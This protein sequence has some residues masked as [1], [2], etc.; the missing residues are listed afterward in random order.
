MGIRSSTMITTVMI[1]RE[2]SWM[3]PGE[4]RCTWVSSVRSRVAYDLFSLLQ[5][6]SEPCN[7]LCSKN[8]R[9]KAISSV[10]YRWEDE[11]LVAKPKWETGAYQPFNRIV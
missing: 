5:S 7:H 8:L 4:Y 11:Y 3:R 2:K 6:E 10:H 1:N 9:A